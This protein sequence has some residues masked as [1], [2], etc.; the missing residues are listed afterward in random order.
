MLSTYKEDTWIHKILI[1][2]M[3]S[4]DR[5]F[6][7]DITMICVRKMVSGGSLSRS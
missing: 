7:I 3:K 5:L 4:K 2:I 6:T 1:Y